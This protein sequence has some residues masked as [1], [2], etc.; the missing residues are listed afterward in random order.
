MNCNTLTLSLGLLLSSVLACF[1]E[2]LTDIVNPLCPEEADA[3]VQREAQAKA[4]QKAF[5]RAWL[6]DTSRFRVVDSQ[7]ISSGG[8]RLHEHGAGRASG[9]GPQ[10]SV[11]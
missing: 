10:P 8:H 7:N 2:D 4:E 6:S 1:G 5:K 9:V 3:I 11:A